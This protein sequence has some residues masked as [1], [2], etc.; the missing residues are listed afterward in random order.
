MTLYPLLRPVA[1]ALPAETAHRA[2]IAALKVM[3]IRARR[4]F[5]PSLASSVA[6]LRFPTPVGLAAGFDKDA[7][8]IGPL[9][10]LGF[11]FV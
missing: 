11:G 7:E 5:P 4:P 3:P 6:G 1:F 9:F 8:V 2:A 10:R